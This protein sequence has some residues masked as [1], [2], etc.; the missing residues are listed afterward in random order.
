MKR[1]HLI[2]T[3]SVQG[4]FYRHNTNKVA[5]QLGLTGFV[6]NLPDGSVEVVAEGG[7]EKIKKLIAFCRKGSE[8]A[9]VEAIKI[10]YQTLTNEFSTFSIKY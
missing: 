1:V 10:Q 5:N 6:R 2:V 8:S 7:E 9:R 4:V 3:G